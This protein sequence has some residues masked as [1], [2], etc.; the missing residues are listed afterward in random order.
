MA[1]QSLAIA[2]MVML[3]G[4]IFDRFKILDV[5]QHNLYLAYASRKLKSSAR[6]LARRQ[7]LGLDPTGSLRN[8]YVYD[9]GYFVT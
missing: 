1:L 5:L 8:H 3:E 9:N 4:G 7:I 6:K 2:A